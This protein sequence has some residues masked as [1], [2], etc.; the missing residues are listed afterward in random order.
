MGIWNKL[1]GAEAA[2]EQPAQNLSSRQ[3]DRKP[4]PAPY[5]VERNQQI[6]AER[7]AGAKTTELAAKYDLSVAFVRTITR[8]VPRPPQTFG[9]RGPHSQE[10]AE[11]NVAM[12]A[13]YE[14]GEENMQTLAEKYGVS[15][16]RVEQILRPT[17]LPSRIKE[18][19]LIQRQVAQSHA[20]EIKT[21]I[22][23]ERERV[24]SEGVELVR[25]GSSIWFARRRLE[26][27]FP[28]VLPVGS[29]CVS[30][31]C[32]QAGVVTK[33]GRWRDRQ[34]KIARARELRA[35]GMSWNKIDE[36]VRAEGLGRITG[37]FVAQYCPDLVGGFAPQPSAANGFEPAPPVQSGP[38][39]I[40]TDDA[41]VQLKTLWFGGSTAQ[42][43]ADI[44]GP[45]FTRNAVIGKL[46]RLRSTGQLTP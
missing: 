6:C 35:A 44:L 7:S 29:S 38:E 20:E 5:T 39:S 30:L 34:P 4:G 22:H 12:A 8:N 2:P 16:Q 33:H 10:I 11:R 1:F 37:T 43:C 14:R 23:S 18:E 13:A 25:Q 24:L 28:G 32:K 27:K 15:R 40:W 45:T 21:A 3:R 42:Q 41:V 46:N 9:P 26:E 36:R 17:G 19:R 31:A